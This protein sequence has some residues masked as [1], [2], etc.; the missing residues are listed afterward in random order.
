MRDRRASVANQSG[1]FELSQGFKLWKNLRC[2]PAHAAV[3]RALA[4]E[5][6]CKLFVKLFAAPILLGLIINLKDNFNRFITFVS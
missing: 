1:V 4:E 3:E 2:K 5:I 6:G